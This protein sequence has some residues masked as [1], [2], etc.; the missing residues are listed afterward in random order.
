MTFHTLTIPNV[1]LHLA[2]ALHIEISSICTQ[3]D[4]NEQPKRGRSAVEGSRTFFSLTGNPSPWARWL[5]EGT[6]K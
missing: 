1:G 4:D 2:V 6:T 3:G 5:A